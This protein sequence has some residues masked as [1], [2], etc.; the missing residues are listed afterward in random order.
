MAQRWFINEEEHHLKAHGTTQ[1]RNPFDAI[2]SK[3]PS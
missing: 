2:G 1:V 3:P